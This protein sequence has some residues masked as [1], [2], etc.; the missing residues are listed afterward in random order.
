MLSQ[1]PFLGLAL[2]LLLTEV[3]AAPRP[4]GSGLFRRWDMS[5]CTA[6]NSGKPIPDSA[7]FKLPLENNRQDM[8]WD[9]CVGDQTTCTI[10][11]RVCYNFEGTNLI[12]DYKTVPGYKYTEADIWLGLSAPTAGSTPTPQFT[13]SNGYCTIATDGSTVHCTIPYSQIT[14]SQ[15]ALNGMCPY[16]AREG[17]IFYLYTNAQL[18]DAA[19][20][21]VKGEGRLSCTDYPTCSNYH[22]Y[23]YWELSYRCTNC[24]VVTTTASPTTASPT[25]PSTTTTSSTSSSTSSTSTSSSSTSSYSTSSMPT[26]SPVPEYCS[27]GTAFGYSSSNPKS[28]TLNSYTPLP[29]SCKRWGWYTTLTT[30]QLSS[31][32]GGP[33]YVG[34]G[35]NDISKATDVGTWSAT[36]SGG[37]VYFTYS[38]SGAYSLADVHVD[39]GCLSFASCSP[40]QFKYVNDAFTDSPAVTSFTTPGL[41]L[42]SCSA[43]KL[44]VIV[45][46]SVNTAK[47]RSACPAP[48]AI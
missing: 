25:T 29:N 46:A 45:H 26:T 28:L 21:V 36:L 47:S 38:L 6:E 13:S 19:G 8:C 31:G 12:F 4:T 48:M 5:L 1:S 20:T 37:N 15:D 10:K 22:Q 18:T 30:A 39:I 44:Y 14:S 3:S 41:K 35:Q 27:F 34:A 24:P 42:P 23:T 43:G 16:G 32:I 7:N 33:L 11:S 9:F 17:L 40:G 2:G